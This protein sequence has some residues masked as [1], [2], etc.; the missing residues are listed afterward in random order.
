MAIMIPWAAFVGWRR[1]HHGILIRFS[2][3]R[4]VGLGTSVRVASVFLIGSALYLWT[5]LPGL[6]L[7]AFALLGSVVAETVFIHFVTQS[8]IREHLDPLIGT[9]EDVGITMKRLWD[10]HY[11]LTLATMTMI[12]GMPF[13]SA[14]LARSP[15]GKS[16]LA[17]WGL[18]MSV[19]F[20]FRSITFALPETVI[21]LY[22]DA[23]TGRELGRFCMRVGVGCAI[24][25]LAMYFSGGA[26]F[27][28]ERVLDSKPD[29]AG[30]ASFALV[31]T[32]LVPVINAQASFLRG[33]LTARHLTGP[34][35]IAILVA[36]SVLVAS[37]VLG[38]A[39]KLDGLVVIGLA[40]TLQVSAELVV[41]QSFWARTIRAPS[42]PA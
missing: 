23:E 40:M 28:F 8:T 24:A 4:P 18:A 3:T 15:D 32:V 19:V 34:R 35:L 17:A 7:A 13:V 16:A 42:T 26:Q 37:L 6:T 36:M 12:L 30:R 20:M 27:L 5:N 25:I 33:L 10:F 29:V 38:V 1:F 31:V 11:P 14:A 22:K 9:A 2:N 39:L 41:L 21:A